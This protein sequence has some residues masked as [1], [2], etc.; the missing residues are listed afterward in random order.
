[1]KVVSFFSGCGG[2]DL[3]FE[4]AGFDVVWA[5]DND[6]VVHETY[7]RNHPRTYL[8]KKDMREI[9]MDEIPECDGFI[10]GPPCQSWSEGGK[11]FK[12]F[13]ASGLAPCSFLRA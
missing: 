1:M 7:L 9:G 8:C 3:G 4:Q 2:L 10:G 11:H 6:P 5:N 13:L 12:T